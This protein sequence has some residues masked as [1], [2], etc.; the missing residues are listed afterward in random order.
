MLLLQKIHRKKKKQANIYAFKTGEIMKERT[1]ETD[2]KKEYSN[3][4]KRKERKAKTVS[5]S[6]KKDYSSK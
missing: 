6:K 3:I 2:R 1:R 5:G 4:I